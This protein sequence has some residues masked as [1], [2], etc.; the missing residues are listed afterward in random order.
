MKNHEV[1]AN[2]NRT[3]SLWK[4]HHGALLYL[5]MQNRLRLQLLPRRTYTTVH[6]LC[7]GT[8]AANTSKTAASDG[9]HVAAAPEIAPRHRHYVPA[10]PHGRSTT[11]HCRSCRSPESPSHQ[12]RHRTAAA[13][14][15][16]HGTCVM[17][18]APTTC[19]NKVLL[20]R[21]C[22]SWRP[23]FDGSNIEH[24]I[25]TRRR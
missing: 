9:F 21:P 19:Y 7:S 5:R 23:I 17:C 6:D 8:S 1:T 12:H 10:H 4:E 20:Q 22:V 2:Q 16:P 18:V 13:R 24:V 25:N 11:C 14:R 3:S 15:V